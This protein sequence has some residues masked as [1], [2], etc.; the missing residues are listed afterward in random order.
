VGF[1]ELAAKGDCLAIAP[2]GNKMS[3][4]DQKQTYAVHK[5]MSAKC[6]KRTH[7]VQQSGSLL[8]HLV[9]ET[10][11]FRRHFNAE[12]LG[13]FGIHVRFCCKMTEIVEVR[14]ADII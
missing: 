7:A 5:S 11:Q 10:E 3:A 4:L 9:S 1:S 8:E 12:R 6:Q 13:G 14:I 2:R